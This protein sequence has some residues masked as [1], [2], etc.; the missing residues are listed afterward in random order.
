ML[1]E[2]YHGNEWLSLPLVTLVF[3]FLFFVA[4]LIRVIFGMRDANQVERLARLPFDPDA[5]REGGD[6]RREANHG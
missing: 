2:F 4:V 5:T 1:Q 6:S 3:V